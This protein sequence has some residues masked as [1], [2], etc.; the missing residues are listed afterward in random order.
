MTLGRHLR[1][2]RREVCGS[3]PLCVCIFVGCW[4]TRTPGDSASQSGDGSCLDP[5]TLAFPPTPSLPSHPCEEGNRKTYLLHLRALRCAGFPGVLPLPTGTLA[6]SRRRAVLFKRQSQ[7]DSGRRHDLAPKT[8]YH[9]HSAGLAR[10]DVL[11]SQAPGVS[12][13]GTT[14]P[15]SKV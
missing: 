5:L 11:S 9:R 2:G 8:C 6:P 7:L 14:W 15:V 12:L 4:G 13:K 10:P 3:N 1:W